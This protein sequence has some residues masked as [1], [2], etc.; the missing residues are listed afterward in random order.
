MTKRNK[1]R[2]VARIIKGAVPAVAMPEFVRPQLATLKSIAP[3]GDQW[4]HEIKFDGYRLQ[5]HLQKGKV[6]V[7]TRNGHNWTNRFPLIAAAFNIP[8]ERAIFDGEV[9]VVHEGRTNFSELQAD[10]ASWQAAPN[11]VLRVRLVVPRRL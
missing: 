8:V 6:T 1:P 10:L 9:V 7:Y 2:F 11:G 4:I 3:T 5:V